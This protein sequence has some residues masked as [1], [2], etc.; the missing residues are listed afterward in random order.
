MEKPKPAED[1]DDDDD[2]EGERKKCTRQQYENHVKDLTPTRPYLWQ[3]GLR[4]LLVLSP[5]S[6][7]VYFADKRVWDG[8]GGEVEGGEHH[9]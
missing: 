8:R 2:D 1:D 4:S 3:T 6:F 9:R 5:P 7:I